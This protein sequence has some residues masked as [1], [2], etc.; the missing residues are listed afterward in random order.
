ML[1]FFNSS[2]VVFLWLLEKTHTPSNKVGRLMPFDYRYGMPVSDQSVPMAMMH[3]PALRTSSVK[4]EDDPPGLIGLMTRR[5]ASIYVNPTNYNR[6]ASCIAV[7][8]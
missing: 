8:R 5:K 2:V 4:F 1:F 3:L 6:R 7:S